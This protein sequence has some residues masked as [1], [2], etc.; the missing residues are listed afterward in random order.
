VGLGGGILGS[1]AAR[2][3]MEGAVVEAA[4]ARGRGRE[5]IFLFFNPF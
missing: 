3:P 2:K 4:T 5:A 1:A